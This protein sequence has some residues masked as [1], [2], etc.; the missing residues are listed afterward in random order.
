ML[1]AHEVWR[2]FLGIWEVRVMQ[3]NVL[4][5]LFWEQAISNFTGEAIQPASRKLVGIGN[6]SHSNR[7]AALAT[8]V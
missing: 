6:F 3:S 5:I 7:S 2:R 4:A 8:P 1:A